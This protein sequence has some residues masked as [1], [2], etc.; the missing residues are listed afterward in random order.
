MPG[1][2]TPDTPLYTENGGEPLK[3]KR[4]YDA[5][6]KLLAEAGYKNEP[7]ILLVATDVAI[8]KA[9]GDVTAD[10]L[11]RIGMNVQYHAL[12]W[13]TVGQRRAKKDPPAQG[14]LAHLP[15]LARRRRLREPG[16][17]YRAGCQRRHR[18]VRLAEIR[19]GAGR[20]SPRGSR[21]PTLPRKRR[22]STN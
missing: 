13:G 2:F 7:I 16:A 11:K 9:Q 6:K 4:D 12:D 1:F 8:T 10:L 14:R 17:L 3:G 5:A 21:R 18:L 15:H 19:H 20:R 22:R